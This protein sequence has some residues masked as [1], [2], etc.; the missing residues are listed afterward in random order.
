M[1]IDRVP[2]G[3]YWNHDHDCIELTEASVIIRKKNFLQKPTEREIRYV[4]LRRVSFQ[5]AEKLSGGY[6]SIRD[7]NNLRNPVSTVQ[8]A[9]ADETSVPV[10]WRHSDAYAKVYAYL[11]EWITRNTEAD[12]EGMAPTEREL[13]IAENKANR[14]EAEPKHA[15]VTTAA[16]SDPDTFDP[17]DIIWA[18]GKKKAERKVKIAELEKTG[19]VYCPK[20]L[21]TS[22][23]ANQKGFSFVRGALGANLG[24]D[25]GM[26]AGG[27]GSKKVIC[28]CLK[29][30][31]QW[32]PG[33]K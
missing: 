15:P 14:Y 27:I 3:Q 1:S 11:C 12:P 30:G 29:C 22:I 13:F 9:A 32:Q 10:S 19:Q 24:L 5:E 4:D 2:V 16:S 18:P 21:S 6:L 33:K 31:H 17:D 8:A 28:T 20:C 23:S 7:K 26:I 25:I